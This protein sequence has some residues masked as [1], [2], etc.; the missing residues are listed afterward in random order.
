M[1][2]TVISCRVVDRVVWCWHSLCSR[3]GVLR[4]GVV[5]QE[6]AKAARSLDRLLERVRARERG[7][8]SG[9]GMGDGGLR[10]LQF[11]FVGGLVDSEGTSNRE[12][13]WL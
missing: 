13:E 9:D 12:L 2:S 5:V 7:W 11:R 1:G 10:L 4:S 8:A 3:M 6:G